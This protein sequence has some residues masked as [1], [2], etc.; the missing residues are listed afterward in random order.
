MPVAGTSE[1]DERPESLPTRNGSFLGAAENNSRKCRPA[2]APS[3]PWASSKCNLDGMYQG[4][5][6]QGLEYFHPIRVNAHVSSSLLLSDCPVDNHHTKLS[7]ASYGT[8]QQLDPLIRR[9]DV[10]SVF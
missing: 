1:Q 7:S 5:T 6:G 10:F 9:F 3:P 4:R 2:L 8:S